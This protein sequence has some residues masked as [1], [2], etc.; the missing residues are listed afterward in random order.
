M[1]EKQFN[2]LINTEMLKGILHITNKEI[3]SLFKAGIIPDTVNGEPIFSWM[4][5]NNNRQFLDKITNEASRDELNNFLI[6]AVPLNDIKGAKYLIKRG[7]EV[8]SYGNL[9]ICYS[10]YLGLEEMTSILIRAGADVNAENGY[11]IQASF[12]KGYTK[13]VDMLCEAGA[14]IKKINNHPNR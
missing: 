3:I 7:A 1:K 2:V 8:R 11:P 4:L 10:S 9:A 14:D 13:I 12:E 5:E 6:K